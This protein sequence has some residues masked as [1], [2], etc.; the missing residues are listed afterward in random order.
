MASPSIPG[1]LDLLWL[2][3]R[4]FRAIVCL[5]AEEAKPEDDHTIYVLR[6][7]EPSEQPVPCLQNWVSNLV[8]VLYRPWYSDDYGLCVLTSDER[9]RAE[10]FLN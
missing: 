9:K 2:D 1:L 8:T 7:G 6:C 3:C 5:K 4:T 10:A